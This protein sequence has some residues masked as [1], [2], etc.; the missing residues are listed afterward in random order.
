MPTN[1]RRSYYVPHTVAPDLGIAWLEM[2]ADVLADVALGEDPNALAAVMWTVI[3]RQ[4]SSTLWDSTPYEPLIEQVVQSGHAYGTMKR[5]RFIPAGSQAPKSRWKH[6][7]MAWEFA[8]TM[9][10][11]VLL[12]LQPDPT[13]GATHF[14]R[15]GTWTPSWAPERAQWIRRGAH[16]FYRI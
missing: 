9:A 5:G 12:G 10:W 14:H 15:R 13:G 8:Q 11:D 3:N 1:E 16:E 4:R 7:R 6:R 2:D